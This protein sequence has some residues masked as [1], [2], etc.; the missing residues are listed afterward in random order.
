MDQNAIALPNGIIKLIRDRVASGNGF[1]LVRPEGPFSLKNKI[2]RFSIAR[3]GKDVNFVTVSNSLSG[4]IEQI[5]VII[6]AFTSHRIDTWFTLNRME[7]AHPGN[8][9]H[10]TGIVG[11]P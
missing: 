8:S 6:T 1:Q 2:R 5:A 3:I 7:N 4:R 9:F 10:L 11:S